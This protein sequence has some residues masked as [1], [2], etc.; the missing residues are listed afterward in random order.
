MMDSIIDAIILDSFE[1]TL[2]L[3]GLPAYIIPFAKFPTLNPTHK[4]PSYF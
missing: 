2:I 3:S 1:I 4:G